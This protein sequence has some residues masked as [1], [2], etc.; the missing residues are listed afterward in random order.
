MEKDV[1]VIVDFDGTLIEGDLERSFMTYLMKF[2]G[3]RAKMLLVA[4]L[5]FPINI[6][7]NKLGYPSLYKSWTLVLNN[8]IE[9]YINQYIQEMSQFIRLKGDV[10]TLLDNSKAEI[11]LL[12]GC[13]EDLL[14]AYLKSIDRIQMFDQVIGCTMQINRFKVKLH[15]YGRSKALFVDRNKYNI[16]IANEKNDRYYL[17]L[18]DEQIYIK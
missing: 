1:C 16:G 8:D 18:C 12:S 6:I 4:L 5:T 2:P 14:K 9:Q 15:P 13:Y 17:N 3:I 7:R 11:V 10:W